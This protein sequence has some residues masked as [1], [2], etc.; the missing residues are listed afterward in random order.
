MGNQARGF[1]DDL[2]IAEGASGR[3]IRKIHFEAGRILHGNGDELQAAHLLH[4][5]SRAL[6]H[7]TGECQGG[8]EAAHAQYD[9]QHR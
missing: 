1:A 6:L 7:S 5:G 2:G 8:D 4:E 3:E 9:S